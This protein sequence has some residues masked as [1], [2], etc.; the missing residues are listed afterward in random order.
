MLLTKRDLAI[1]NFI[2]EFGFCEIIQ[3]EK[4]FHFKRPRAYK[5]IQRLVKEGLVIHKR[6]FH[7]TY[8]VFYLPRKGAKYTDLPIVKKIP[9]DNYTHQLAI[10]EVYFDLTQQYPHATWLSERRLKQQKFIKG[11]GK[12]RGHLADGMLL[13]PDNKKIAIE[14]ELTM[15]SKERLKNIFKG[16]AGQ[17]EINEVWYYCSPKVF[18]K[19]TKLVGDYRFIQVKTL[20]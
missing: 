19:I 3:I 2:N 11:W 7:G 6:I 20:R 18:P 5:I 14:V 15:K 16:Y 12:Q 9:K 4:K 10:I 17:F 1:L 13:M 8:G